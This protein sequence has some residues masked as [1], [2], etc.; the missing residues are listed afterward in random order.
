MDFTLTDDQQMLKTLVERFVADRYDAGARAVYR[1]TACGYSARNMQMLAEMGLFALAWPES[2]GGLEG[3]P[4]EI[5]TVME[6]LGRGLAVEPVLETVFVAGAM[7]ARLCPA[8]LRGEWLEAVLHG[9]RRV[10]FAF[11]EH[12][13]RFALT[14]GGTRAQA[15]RLS[16]GKT[17]VAAGADLWIVTARD[18]RGDSLYLVR[19]DATG[20]ATRDYRLI[21][22]SVASELVFDAVAATRIGD[23]AA[24]E[25]LLDSGRIG[26]MAEMV[27]IMSRIFD[28]TLDYV[29]NRKQFGVA[30][31]SFQ[32]IQHRLADQYAAL[33][34]SR[35]QLYRAALA[36][37]TERAAA[38]AGA[39]S[40]I[41][42]RAI[43]LGEECIQFHGGMGVSDELAIGHG[44]KRLML[45]A[46]LFGDAHHEAARYAEALERAGGI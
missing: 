19:A 35:S 9:R 32:A 20:V 24:I 4:I 38:I 36:E 2:E 42:R 30:I 12:G 39:K 11:A 10:A 26:A 6:A 18:E 23:L 14:G 44:H 21:D 15:G 29:R 33:E 22:G 7:L 45:L 43:R 46:S 8:E 27:G 40:F 34:L 1:A 41:A 16:G 17:M 31:G 5:M 37:G 3:G 25:G 13:A 28:E